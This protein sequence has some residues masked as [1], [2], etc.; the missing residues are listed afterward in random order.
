M[1]LKTEFCK[2]KKPNISL[3]GEVPKFV[4]LLGL[5]EIFGGSYQ[6]LSLMSNSS[7]KKSVTKSQLHEIKILTSQ[8]QNLSF[9]KSSH[10]LSRLC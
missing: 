4:F 7:D 10:S 8:N 2:I 1:E 5:I 6:V 3:G 9:T